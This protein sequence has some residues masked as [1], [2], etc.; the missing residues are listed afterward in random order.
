MGISYLSPR[1]KQFQLM[2][3]EVHPD[4]V[5]RQGGSRDGLS[6]LDGSNQKHEG[7]RE[8]EARP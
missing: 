1:L 4:F 7:E 8:G 2:D 6:G 3:A 5:R